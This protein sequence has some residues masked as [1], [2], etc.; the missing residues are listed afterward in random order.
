MRPDVGQ[1]CS[2]AHGHR[3][4][5]GHGK[6]F[7]LGAG[8]EQVGRQ[9]QPEDGVAGHKTREADPPRH[10]QLDRTAFEFGGQLAI[11][12]DREVEVRG[13]G[14]EQFEQE[15]LVLGSYETADRYQLDLRFAA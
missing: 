1:H 8:N 5:H 14:R 7:P 4:E 9:H 11:P 10:V 13:Q 12:D 3:L 15:G 6:P 2:Q